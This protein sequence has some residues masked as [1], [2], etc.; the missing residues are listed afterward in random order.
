MGYVAFQ[1]TQTSFGRYDKANQY[2]CNKGFNCVWNF[3]FAEDVCL[4]IFYPDQRI[5]DA[6]N[7][8]HCLI[9]IQAGNEKEWSFFL[10][11][12]SALCIFL[13][14]FVNGFIAY[15]RGENEKERDQIIRRSIND[16][17]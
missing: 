9:M 11:T 17:L 10:I 14:V 8:G 7:S 13:I 5:W 16:Q 2:T 4:L 15:L 6:E 3:D 12:V 1:F